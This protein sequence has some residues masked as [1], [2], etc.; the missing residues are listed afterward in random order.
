MAQ[1]KEETLIELLRYVFPYEARK[2]QSIID[3]GVDINYEDKNGLTPLIQS[4]TSS[5]SLEKLKYILSFH[6]DVNY[7]NKLGETALMALAKHFYSASYQQAENYDGIR[8]L[9]D[10]GANVNLQNKNGFT[11]LMYIIQRKNVENLEHVSL[12]V[13]NGAD[14]H[15]KNKYNQNALLLA[16]D[17]KKE[18]IVN[19]LLNI[20]GIEINI[21][22]NQGNTPLGLAVQQNNTF[23]SRKLLE[24]GADPNLVNKL[25]IGPIHYAASQGNIDM[26]NDLIT[27]GANVNIQDSNKGL[28]PLHVAVEN[29]PRYTKCAEILLKAG[30]DPNVKDKDGNTP[31]SLT[32]NQA[33]ISLL[34]QSGA[35]IKNAKGLLAN[36]LQM[37]DI[38][39]VEALLKQGVD[40]NSPSSSDGRTP[41]MIALV[42]KNLQK[43]VNVFLEKSTNINQQ[44]KT[45]K[46][47]LFLACEYENEKAVDM[48]LEAKADPNIVNEKGES[49]LNKAIEV[50]NKSLIH[51]LVEAGANINN[52]DR[53]KR[54]PLFYLS[55]YAY[56]PE[57]KLFIEKGADVDIP[58]VTGDTALHAAV[59]GKSI[60]CVK[61]LLDAD[62]NINAQNDIKSTPLHLAVG[63]G[64]VDIIQ[65]LLEEGADTKLTTTTGETPFQWAKT[66]E[67][68]DL[69]KVAELS[70]TPFWNGLSQADIE[71]FDT[72]FE[73]SPD[74][75]TGKIPAN[76]YACCPFCL[77]FLFRS[78][79][80]NYMKH[81][82]LA[83]QNT[84]PHLVLYNKYK[85]EKGEVGWCTICG[86]PALGHRHV[87]LNNPEDP[88][89]VEHPEPFLTPV[90]PG[91]TPFSS[92]CRGPEGGGGLPE[93]LIRFRRM[94][95]V[96]KELESQAGK[97]TKDEVVRIMVEEAWKAAKN[98]D[99]ELGK[100]VLA[101]KKFNLPTANFPKTI[102]NNQVASKRAPR[103]RWINETNPAAKP[104]QIEKG[105]NSL[106]YDDDV[107]VIRFHCRQQNGTL[108]SHSDQQLIQPITLEGYIAKQVSDLE[109]GI[110]ENFGVCFAS[111][112]CQGILFPDQV[113]PFINQ[114]LYM[115]YRKAFNTFFQGKTLAG[116]VKE[117]GG[118]VDIFTPMKKAVC[119]LPKKG[120][121]RKTMKRKQHKKRTHKR[122]Y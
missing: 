95:E 97:I 51:K 5:F 50:K 57:V 47:A 88:F 122:K 78:E 11:A 1:S 12:L 90:L 96:A 107:E 22:S 117:G 80:C 86:R 61:L 6:P 99:P 41:L 114:T 113:K 48:L 18:K 53:F 98:T 82:C 40:V 89:D 93:K 91:Q 77:K 26:L 83:E 46:T 116:A 94:R 103:I 25:G 49:P 115:K 100:K 21:Q 72:V 28:T 32:Q 109:K 71:K 60:E 74:G 62:A 106:S 36:A 29:S 120:G 55:W 8:L 30:A 20:K 2:I 56:I 84:T 44:D 16:V 79:A 87:A 10:N 119:A 15:I 31:L 66:K 102:P 7:Q 42:N 111:P 59:I 63:E 45:G 121:K 35:N 118:S 37:K 24:N 17:T 70:R 9:L 92:D 34:V 39:L 68:K 33:T 4:A 105:F 3:S 14:V 43:Y 65:L 19:Y 38:Q 73:T 23:L 13:R 27:A 104:E 52:L 85:N 67:I 69:I 54:S 110:S 81:N 76:D 112:D 101:E 64:E 58:S 108:Y 75:L